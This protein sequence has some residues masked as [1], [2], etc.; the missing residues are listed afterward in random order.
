VLKFP[1]CFYIIVCHESPFHKRSSHLLIGYKNSIHCLHDWV[2]WLLDS[3]FLLAV[4][5]K[6]KSLSMYDCTHEQHFFLLIHTQWATNH[7]HVDTRYWM[8]L[9]SSVIKI[10]TQ[11][12][13]RMYSL[14]SKLRAL[15]QVM[16]NFKKHAL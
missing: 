8:I 1:I 10:F 2:Q 5:R 11:I 14:H 6:T 15:L 12:S 4:L 16:I 9:L 3:R 13:I 7:C